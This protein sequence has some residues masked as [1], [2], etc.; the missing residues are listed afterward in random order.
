[1]RGWGTLVERT[2]TVDPCVGR[3]EADY[4]L[5]DTERGLVRG[6]GTTLPQRCRAAAGQRWKT[7]H[8]KGRKYS[9][10]QSG[11]VHLILAIPWV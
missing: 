9:S 7:L 6:S 2:Q 10:P 5:G 8:L 4:P 3:G 1:M 11:F